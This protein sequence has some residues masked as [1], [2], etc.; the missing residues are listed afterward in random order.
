[1]RLVILLLAAIFFCYT[2]HAQQKD[3]TVQVGANVITL[4][5]VVLDKKLD[6]ARFIQKIKADS[7]FYKAFKNLRILGYTSMNDI[8]MLNRKNEIIASLNSRTRQLRT[9]SCRYWKNMFLET[10]MMVITSLITTPRT[11]MHQ[12]FLR[13]EWYV[14]KR[15]SWA[16][17]V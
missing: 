4:S 12:F 15:T 11:C 9:D 1:M 7:S 2:G 16:T 10:C 5:E 6:A 8:R 17:G 14:V 13:K 3:S